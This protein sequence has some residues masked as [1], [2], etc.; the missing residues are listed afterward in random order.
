MTTLSGAPSEGGVVA[1]NACTV[2]TH[3]RRPYRVSTVSRCMCT[4]AYVQPS[5][6]V[7]KRG[8]KR[9]SNGPIPDHRNTQI[10]VTLAVK[11][12]FF[13]LFSVIWELGTCLACPQRGTIL[14]GPQIDPPGTPLFWPSWRAPPAGRI[15]I[16]IGLD[17]AYTRYG[18]TTTTGGVTYCQHSVPFRV[19]FWGPFGHMV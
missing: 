6:E 19:T 2:P 15:T 3:P 18:D 16:L 8:P 4:L 11:V 7:P 14:G 13:G 10:K 17:I 9:G 5:G 1:C 12:T